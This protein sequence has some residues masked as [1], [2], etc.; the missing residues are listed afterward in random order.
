VIPDAFWIDDR[1]GA[2]E[3]DA[4]AVRLGAVDR[5]VPTACEVELLEAFFQEFPRDEAGF[6]GAAF[7]LGLIGAEEDV[8]L[9]LP[10]AE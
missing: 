7:R 10:D 1:D 3:A 5:R 4:Q 8:A 6:L 2:L 9:D